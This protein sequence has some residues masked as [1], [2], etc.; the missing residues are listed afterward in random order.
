MNDRERPRA[1]QPPPLSPC[2]RVC[3]LDAARRQCQGCGRTT[4]EIQ[5]WPLLGDAEKR[6][7]L[8]ELPDRLR[9]AH[10]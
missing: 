9:R 10:D 7:V 5:A 8:A 1:T 2:I 4:A 3:L 6:A